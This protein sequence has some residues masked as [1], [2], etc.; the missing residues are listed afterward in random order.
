MLIGF[1]ALVPL[2]TSHE[3]QNTEP[4]NPKE[5]TYA[6]EGTVFAFLQAYYI[7][8]TSSMV[9]TGKLLT[10]IFKVLLYIKS[11]GL[12]IILQNITLRGTV[13]STFHI[14]TSITGNPE[15]CCFFVPSCSSSFCISGLLWD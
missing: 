3:T 15:Q 14:N 13:Y 11:I 4:K 7:C 12:A 2:F 6:K 9:Y 5:Q 1:V 8:Q 10:T